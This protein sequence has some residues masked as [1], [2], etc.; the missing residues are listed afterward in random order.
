MDEVTRS[1]LQHIRPDMLKNR[2]LPSMLESWAGA[3]EFRLRC[4]EHEADNCPIRCAK[5]DQPV[6]LLLRLTAGILCCG[7]DG[8]AV[9]RRRRELR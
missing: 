1:G 6:A 9:R 2:G 3:I 7:C 5:G 4:Y 8:R